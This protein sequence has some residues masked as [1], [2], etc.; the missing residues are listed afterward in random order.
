MSPEGKERPDAQQQLGLN[1]IPT[2]HPPARSKERPRCA[3]AA[4]AEPH[5]YRPASLTDQRVRG[6]LK[7]IAIAAIAPTAPLTA[8]TKSGA[9]RSAAAPA[10][11]MATPWP[12]LMP[13]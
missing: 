13:P 2:G 6:R 12:R 11:I 4:G 9:K 10:T 7:T 1:P 3:A 5:T 8:I